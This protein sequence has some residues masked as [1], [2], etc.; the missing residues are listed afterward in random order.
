MDNQSSQFNQ[1][2]QQLTL[3]NSTAVLV[4]G[5]ISIPT[6]FC[7]GIIGLTCGIIALILAS[8]DMTRYKVDPSLYKEGSVKNLKAGK[9]C[10]IV[11]TSLSAIYV[12]VVLF[13]LLTVGT[14]ILSH[15]TNFYQHNY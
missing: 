9:V 10:A 3:P 12:L 7:Y 13:F 6:C 11:G 14:A 15:P 5:I 8:K 1:F 4:L 2:G